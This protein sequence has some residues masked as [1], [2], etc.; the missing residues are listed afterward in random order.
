[1]FTLQKDNKMEVPSQGP[2]ICIRTKHVR[3]TEGCNTAVFLWDQNKRTITQGSFHD[4]NDVKYTL[5]KLQ[6]VKHI[7]LSV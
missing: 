7:H 6:V 1:M 2:Q 5:Q 3:M 4:H